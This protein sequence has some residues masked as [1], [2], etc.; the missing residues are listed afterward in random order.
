M[1]WDSGTHR[2]V[3]VEDRLCTGSEFLLGFLSAN[4]Y[5]EIADNVFFFVGLG[6]QWYISMSGI[7]SSDG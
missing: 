3:Y 5:V 2:G 6:V 4:V 1:A 7:Y